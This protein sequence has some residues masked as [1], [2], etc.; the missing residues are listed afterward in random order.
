MLS[1][2][3]S[4]ASLGGGV[5]APRPAPLAVAVDQLTDLQRQL[6][7]D[8]DRQRQKA[9]A[10][11]AELGS[12]PAWPLVLGAL[13]DP[14]P[15]VADEAQLVLSG[16]PPMLVPVLF[17]KAGL[18][19]KREHVAVRVAEALGRLENPG[20]KEA[21]P[22]ALKHQDSGV[23][24]TLL[25]SV[26]RLALARVFSDRDDSMIEALFA[27]ASKDQVPA[28]RAHAWLALG[29]LAP[30]PCTER[31]EEL[32]EEDELELRA[33]A[34]ELIAALPPAK[35]LEAALEAVK[36]PAALV[37]RRVYEVLASEAN[38][39]A[40]L[41]LIGALEAESELRLSWRLIELLQD[42]SGM[43]Y[44]RDPRAWQRWAE[45]LAPDWKP[46]RKPTDRDYGARSAAFV[47]LPLLSDRISFLIDFSGSMW[48]KREG[49]SRKEVVDGELRRAL[50]ALPVTAEFNVQPFTNTPL[51]WQKK[52]VPAKKTNVQRALK[53]FEG[54]RESGKGNFWDAAME[55]M[56]DPRMDTIMVLTDGAPTGGYRWNLRL[57]KELFAHENR[58]R[59]V[60][61]DALLVDTPKS[62]VRYWEEM[63]A[64]SGGRCISVDL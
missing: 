53:Y 52:L 45:G 59:G 57:M 44:G 62:L 17:G 20:P 7:S 15:R 48:E 18:G 4:L 11:L 23:R 63:T 5:A 14:S 40:T 38:R 39:E 60:A 35:R 13:N 32:L 30:V 46:E 47:G 10:G 55:A 49:S 27:I 19:S 21:W 37:R 51:R 3:L 22:R 1:I 31:R 61:L 41:E 16:V 36:D 58:F 33:A 43:K 64:A 8:D 42:L 25:W 24:R 6:R 9:V 54:C 26:E 28:V 50:E 12:P 29:A 56:A 2:L 34:A